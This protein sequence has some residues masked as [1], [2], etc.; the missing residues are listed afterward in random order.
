MTSVTSAL[1]AIETDSIGAGVHIHAFAAIQRDAVVENDAV[2]H[3]HATV[4]PRARIGAGCVLEPG[5]VIGAQAIIGPGCHIGAGSVIR[6]GCTIGE[7]STIGES[8]VLGA[9]APDCA[10][11]LVVG[12]RS[13]V[14]SHCVIYGGSVIGEALET[15]H[16]VV[17]RERSSIGRN[18]RIGNFSDVEGDCAIGDYCRFHGYVHVGKGARIGSFVWLYSLTTLLNDPLPPSKIS[19]PVSIEDGVVVCVGATIMPD[20]RIGKGAFIAARTTVSGQVPPG[21][22]VAGENGETR[23]HVSGL[24]HLASGTRHPWMRHFAAAYPESA[25]GELR[26]LLKEILETKF[27]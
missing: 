17:I 24:V 20:A 23:G 4:G 11:P 3:S 13:T 27:S 10:E 1:A 2:I 7:G 5:A 22:V 15:G 9:P 12:A 25:Q 18:L 14:R 8:C 26:A 16:H 6:T 21:A 19:A